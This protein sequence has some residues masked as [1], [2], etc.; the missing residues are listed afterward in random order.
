MVDGAGLGCCHRSAPNYFAFCSH[1]FSEVV[2]AD[3]FGRIGCALEIGQKIEW[4]KNV[5][6]VGGGGFGGRSFGSWGGRLK[7][8]HQRLLDPLMA[9]VLVLVIVL[10][11]IVLPFVL[12]CS[13]RW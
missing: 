4:S 10:P 1:L 3:S 5:V 13:A 2:I 9:A 7:A 8:G 6:V 12:T 11:R